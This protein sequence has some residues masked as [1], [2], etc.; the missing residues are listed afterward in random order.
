MSFDLNHKLW[1]ATR[2][3]IGQLIK[4]QNRLKK[5]EPPEEK[6][7]SFKIFSELYVLYVELVNKLSFIYHNTFQVQKRAVVRILVESATQQLLRL[8][9]ELKGMELSEYV[10]IDKALIA[11]RLTP[12]DLVIWRS[13]QFLYRRPLDVQNIVA[14]NKLY[15]NDIEKVE[16]EAQDWV[17]VTEAVTLIQAHERARRARVYKSN[18]NYDKK[19][20]LKVLQRKKINYRFTFKPDQAMSIPV[21]RTIFAADFIK[22]VESCENLKEKKDVLEPSTDNE[23]LERLNK[24]RDDAASK[25]QNCWRRYK[26]RKIMRMR[27]RFK[28]E[29]YGMKKHRKLK[30]PNRFA[31]SVFEMYKKEM[32]KK[33]LDEEYIQLITDE[34]TRLLQMRTPWMMEDISDH[35]RAWFK[36]FYEKTGN[37]HPYP[38]PIKTGTVLVVIDETMTPLEFQDTLGKKPMTKAERQKLAEKKKAEKQKQKDKIRKQKMKDAKRRKKLKDAGIIDVAY[39]M[40]SSKA[41]ANIEEAMKQFALDWRNI[42]EYLNKNH[43]PIKDWVTEEELAK[44]HQE[45]RGLVDE[46]MRI[47]YELLRAALAKDTKT[48]YKAQKVKKAKA[49]KEKK[50]KKV[51][52]MTADRTLDSLYQEL[53]DEGIIE[54]VSHKDFDEFIADFNFLANDTRDEDGLTTVGPAKG[55]IKMIIQ[56]SMLGMGEFDIDKPK[57]ILLIGPLNSGKKLLCNIIASELDAVFINLSPEKVFKFADNMKYFLHVVMKVAKAFQPA[58]LYIEE[59][60]RVFLKKIPP[61][62]KEINPTLLGPSIPKGILKNIKKTDKVVL[63]G[64]SNMPWS[65][66]GKFK[67]AFQKVLLIPRC[68]YGTSFLLW[69]ELMTENVEDME[70]HAYSALARVLQAYNSGDIAQNISQTL[71]VSRRMRLNNEA[72]DPNEFLE[73]FL[74]KHDEPIFPPEQKIMDKF[75]KWFG[76]S[77]KFLKLRRKFMAKKMAKQKKKK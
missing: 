1:V 30:R 9:D 71:D 6:A 48:K 47:E 69:L 63:L 12:R 23:E 26:T 4:K 54:E 70:E 67:K 28:E 11:R 38:D 65:A 35:I 52:D 76:K 8:K 39:E 44:I 33:K 10:Y 77:N 41:I 42:D 55:D 31:N 2:K 21:K 14:D 45:L 50:K 74:S 17:K 59:A 56:E 40:T 64:T 62:L 51:K 32:L 13:P 5:M 15:M 36:E 53:K 16:K 34:R 3:D 22:D 7:I 66:K 43:D 20:F 18:I 75:D 19:K 29:L 68:D 72:L 61:E 37:F 73:Y 49:K 46:Y 57:S 27:S 25:I 60:H 24:L 58:I